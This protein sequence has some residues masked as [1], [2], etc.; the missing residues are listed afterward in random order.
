MG[1]AEGFIA[2]DWGTSN[3]RGYRIAADG[4]MATEFEDDRGILN[5]GP[6]GFPQALAQVT[7][8]LGD[9]PLLLAG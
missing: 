4:V 2:V 9:A 8:R 5:V 6:D 3:R 7:E 1:W